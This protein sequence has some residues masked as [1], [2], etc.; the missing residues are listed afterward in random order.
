MVMP[1][2][3]G[4]EMARRLAALKPEVRVVFMSGYSDQA[5]GDQSVLESGTLFLQKPF[6]MDALMRT[7]RR[8]LD[9]G[10]S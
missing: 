5:M 4:S 9:A 3:S 6:T 2:M 7:I 8:A 1:R 10:P